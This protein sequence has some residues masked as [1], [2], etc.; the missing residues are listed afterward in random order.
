MSKTKIE[1]VTEAYVELSRKLGKLPSIT[2]CKR[3]GISPKTIEYHFGGIKELKEAAI[4]ATPS[5]ESM[6]VPVRL[7]LNDIDAYRTDAERSNAKKNNKIITADASTLDYLKKFADNV[8]S[9]RIVPTT[10]TK[11]KHSSLDRIV[12]VVLSDLHFGSDL[13]KVETGT[14]DYGRVE[15]SRRLAAIVKQV[16]EYKIQYRDRTKLVVLL[17]GDIIDNQLHDA[18]TGAPVSEQCARAI[19]LLS[20]AIGYWATQFGEVEVYATTGNHGRNTARH[21]ERAIHQKWDSLETIVHF[22]IKASLSRIKNVKFNIPMTP[23]ASYEV[24]GRKIAFTHGDTVINAGSVATTI[25]TKAIENQINKINASLR[26]KDEYAAVILGHLH[27]P[28]IT[29]LGNGVAMIVNGS[30]VPPDEFAVSIGVMETTNGQWVFESV[31]GYPVGDQRL[32]VVN[33]QDDENKELDKI[34]VPWSEF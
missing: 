5:L 6:N 27:I 20:Q 29:F 2:E 31:K 3:F 9:G 1:L 34:I 13:K 24:F 12:T 32:I 23:L 21:H 15:E 28:S 18:R 22:A 17:N 26:D 25:N 33:K 11:P 7:T 14:M 19:H 30:L 10:K 8:F 16:S 4:A